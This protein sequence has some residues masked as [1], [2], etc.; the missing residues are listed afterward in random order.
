M[1]HIGDEG[2]LLLVSTWPSDPHRVEALDTAQSAD[3]TTSTQLH[4]Q[5]YQSVS[6]EK[7]THAA[8]VFGMLATSVCM[9]HRC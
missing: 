9:S 2:S 6:L 7:H 1:H 5:V 8:S 3:Q 4:T